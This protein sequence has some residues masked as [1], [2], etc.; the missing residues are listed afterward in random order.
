MMLEICLTH[1]PYDW[2]HPRSR[3]RLTFSHYI[4][5]KITPPPL[6]EEFHR[7]SNAC[8]CS[9]RTA[10]LV[11]PTNMYIYPKTGGA[12]QHAIVQPFYQPWDS[13]WLV[14]ANEER[15]AIRWVRSC[16]LGAGAGYSSEEVYRL[17]VVCPK[18]ARPYGSMSFAGDASMRFR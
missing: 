16:G 6:R 9:R 17:A 2:R 8:L 15:W 4:L 10:G 13:T 12:I 7:P 11:R 3:H 5:T 14:R 18:P 1:K